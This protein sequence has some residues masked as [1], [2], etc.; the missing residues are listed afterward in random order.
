MEEAVKTIWNYHQLFH[1]LVPCDIIFVLGS[2]DLRVADRA[3]ELYKQN[4][5]PIIVLS[6]G[7]GKFTEGLFPKSEADSLCERAVSLGVPKEAIIVENKSTNCGENISFTR[8]ILEE[9]NITVN[10]LIALQKP[11]MERRTLATICK[12]WP[13]VEVQVSSPQF[14][15]IDSYVEGNTCFD[16][17]G[18]IHNMVGDL[19]RIRYYPEMGFQTEQE[20]PDSV[21]SAFKLLVENG[22]CDHLLKDK[23]KTIE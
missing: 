2:H 21:K 15:D 22:Y 9:R 14:P 19:H 11:Y 13:G 1:T 17:N 8:K 5:A 23:P 7:L 4:L 20:I 12:Q 6:G 10:K 16:R 18:I 3:A